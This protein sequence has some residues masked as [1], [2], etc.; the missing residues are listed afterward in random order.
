MPRP[1][2]L[3]C[4]NLSAR[5]LASDPVFHARTKH[6]EIDVHFVRDKVLQQMLQVN[7]VPST[8][9]VADILT[10]VLPTA[11]FLVL[12]DKLNLKPSLSSLRGYV[13]VTDTATHELSV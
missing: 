9:Q 11:C 7:F 13:R 4:D 8:D 10:K 5:S 2:I 1:P 12:R 3:W 6:I